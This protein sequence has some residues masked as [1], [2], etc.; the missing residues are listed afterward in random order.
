MS[1]PFNSTGIKIPITRYFTD[2]GNDLESAGPLYERSNAVLSWM[3]PGLIYPAP[4]QCAISVFQIPKDCGRQAFADIISGARRL[5]HD[6]FGSLHASV[7]IAFALPAWARFCAEEGRPVPTG[8]AFAEAG[9]TPFEP[10]AFARSRGVIQNSGAHVWFIIKADA[11]TAVV[12]I[13][14]A[15]V[16]EIENLGVEAGNIYRVAM[17]S[18][19]NPS[20]PGADKSGRVLGGRFKENLR[21][22]VSPVEILEH[23]LVGDEN[24]GSA[25]GTFVFAQRFQLNWSE[26]HSKTG[27]EIDAVIGRRGY[28]DELVPSFDSRSH[29]RSSHAYD[30]NGNTIKLLRVGLPFGSREGGNVETPLIQNVG[31]SSKS[32]EQGIYFVGMAKSAQ[33]IESI[34]RSQFHGAETGF[35]RDRLLSGSFARSDLGGFFYAPSIRELGA[36]A[37]VDDACARAGNVLDDWRRFPG[38]DWTRFNRHY[39]KRSANGRMFYNHQDYLHAIGTSMGVQADSPQ[40]P[41]LR[42]QFLLERLF[43]KWDDTWY[44]AQKP[45]ELAPLRPQLVWF[46]SDPRNAAERDQ[47]LVDSPHLSDDEARVRKAAQLIMESPVAIRSAWAG[48]LFC[49]LASRLDGVGRRGGGGMDLCDIHPLDLLAG[50]MPAQS[51]AEGRYFI[52]FVR[53][54]D[55][56]QESY[57]WFTQ[58]LGPNSGVGHVV[59]GYEAVLAEGINGL[60]A[61]IDAAETALKATDLVRAQVAAPFYAGSRLA[62]K[63]LTEYLAGLAETTTQKARSLPESQT[64]EKK[65]LQELAGRLDWL[66]SGEPPRTLL[67]AAQLILACHVALHLVG[68]PV[69]IG[70]LDR[71]L[72]PFQERERLAYDALQEIVDCFWLKLAEKVLL[73][74]IFIDDRQQIGNMAMGNR[75]GP[76]PKGQSVN[77]WIQQL[78]IGGRN[79]D[80]TW[81][82]SDLTLACLRASARLPFNAPVLSLRVSKDMPADWRKLLLE[83]AAKGQLSGGASPILLNDDKIIP[84]LVKSGDD[85]VPPADSPN[86][87]RWNSKVRIADAHDY[88]CDGCYE[89]QFVGANWFHLG[90][91]ILLQPLEFALNQ[92]RQIQGA[93]PVDLFGRNMSFRSPA[94]SDLTRY[95][96]LEELF[97]KHLKWGY[98][99]QMEGTVADFGRMEQVCPSPFLNLFINDCLEKGQ[100]IYGGGARYN[101]FGPC[102]T[103]LANTINALWAIRVMCFE[104]ETAVTTLPELVQAL[105]CNWGENMV[106]PLVHSTVL[107]ADSGRVAETSRHFR[108]LREIALSMPHWGRGHAEID[109]FGNRISSRVA[110][111]A[112]EV[113]TKPRPALARLY[114]QAASRFG[115]EQHPFGGFSMQPG[116]GTFASYVEQGIGCGASADGRLSGHPLATDMSPAP[117][118]L[119]LPATSE[120]QQVAN[121]VTMLEGLRSNDSFGYANGAPIDLNISEDMSLSRLVTI[122]E[123]FTNGAGSN[124]LT[125]TTADQTTFLNAASS[126]EA[127]DLLRVRMG[128]WTEMFVAMHTTHQ[129]VHPR[130]PYSV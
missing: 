83:E 120:S 80:G 10:Q 91:T 49:N 55:D 64:F 23:V 93:G 5:I 74:R 82:Y 103:S 95:E 92:G 108:R 21:N 30:A 122:L 117:S 79:P 81:E 46:F 4:W 13:S 53:D 77:Q 16:A 7:C 42:V 59:P 78:T 12:A 18:R 50:S 52:D 8:A 36:G 130:R 2:G 40:P 65:N 47:I 100:D 66:A 6:R 31:A 84:A 37:L 112:V 57:R 60:F 20:L 56:E 101:V 124:V 105:L 90:G 125:V 63:G 97:F 72:R 26:I 127:F 39:E 33:R 68:E 62:A 70:R 69:A 76:Y 89:P 45:D 24:P 73:N 61:R 19:N 38:I 87:G 114:E 27:S 34:L 115:T 15:L 102:F 96:D 116:V 48:R 119:D 1:E 22:P 11:E 86:A 43:S 104:P 88:A 54:D 128:G 9:D 71:L 110:Q 35:G 94:A 85:I 29:I 75:A 106:D 113:M 109:A 17:Q 67:E 28:T 58:G 25:G 99:R 107:Q 44:R 41:S 121:A 98:A 3:Q 118:P 51:L 14:D 32:D 123:A 111:I 129:R 126:P